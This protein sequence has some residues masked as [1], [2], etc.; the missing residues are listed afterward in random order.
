MQHNPQLAEFAMQRIIVLQCTLK[1]FACRQVL[2]VP[3]IQRPCP[4]HLHGKRTW[5]QQL[6]FCLLGHGR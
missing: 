1:L 2:L 5:S 4:P 3:L 6:E